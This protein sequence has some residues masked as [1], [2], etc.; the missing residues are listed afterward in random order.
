MKAI[1]EKY[2]YNN[3]YNKESNDFEN[4]FLSHPNYPSLFAITDTFDLLSIEN[5]AA[6]VPKEQFLE[7]PESFLALFK[8]E[9]TLVK[10]EQNSIAVETEGKSKQKITTDEFLNNWNGIVVAIEPN[11]E[12]VPE[13]IN[14]FNNKIVLLGITLLLLFIIEMQLLTFFS[15]IHL[16]I[17]LIGFFVSVLIIDEKLHKT[18]GIASKICTL[19]KNTS[20]DS[21][22]KSESAAITTWLDFSDLP[23][24]FF[25]FGILIALINEKALI[26]LSFVS[27]L[28][29]PLILYSLWLQKIK[30]KKWCVL[31]LAI[32]VLL[33]AQSSLFLLYESV[34]DF[35]YEVFLLSFV[36]VAPIWFFIKPY[37]FDLEK[38]KKETLELTKFKRRFTV[39][40]ALQKEVVNVEELTTISKIE[41]GLQSAPVVVTLILSPSC[42]HCHTAFKEAIELMKSNKERVKLAVFFNLNPDNKENPFYT[43]AENLF[44][45]DQDVP[46]KIEEA[47]SDWHIQNMSLE[48]WTEKW[49]Q[50]LISLSVG[51]NLRSQYEWCLSNDFNYTPVKLVNNKIIPNEYEIKELRYFLSNFEE[52]Q[53]VLV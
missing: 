15:S 33:I 1:I 52:E 37:F 35:N 8:D 50:T 32:S 11:L 19:S 24:L 21:V 18:D 23:I 29:I 22:I 14:L 20:C 5:I 4:L 3:N 36:V 43:I 53:P 47:I 10:K 45:I 49:S 40:N 12:A 9:V 51:D 39:F 7:L 31:C 28:S 41:L 46:D 30:L 48:D 27:V 2:L 42:G 6:K 44:Q 17:L 25:S 38:R 16:A 34:I 26:A 13:K